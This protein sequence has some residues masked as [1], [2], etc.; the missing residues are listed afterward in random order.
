M[1]LNSSDYAQVYAAR[2]TEHV[3]SPPTWPFLM[4]VAKPVARSHENWPT[5]GRRS[6]YLGDRPVVVPA[7]QELAIWVE[8]SRRTAVS[9]QVA[10]KQVSSMNTGHTKET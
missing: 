7:A 4:D 5:T 3:K 6:R 10:N 2:E 1:K 8:T 9:G